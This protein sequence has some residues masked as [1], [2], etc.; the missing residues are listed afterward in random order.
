MGV[1]AALLLAAMLAA[2]TDSLPT[3]PERFSDDGSVSETDAQSSAAEQDR[4]R[5]RQRLLGEPAEI[6]LEGSTI[7]YT[8]AISPVSAENL[9]R[10][11]LGAEMLVNTLVIN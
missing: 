4:L 2:C 3:A 11:A 1:L 10:V 6:T 5:E 9:L 7:Y 8:G